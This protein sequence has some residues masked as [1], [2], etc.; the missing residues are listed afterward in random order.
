MGMEFFLELHIIACFMS[1][2]RGAAVVRVLASHQCGLGS[3][4]GPGLDPVLCVG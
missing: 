3:I 2:S 4:P 1:G